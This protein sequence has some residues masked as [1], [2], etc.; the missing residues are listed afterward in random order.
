MG[1][2]QKES[3]G[4]GPPEPSDDGG[5]GDDNKVDRMSQHPSE[6]TEHRTTVPDKFN[7]RSLAG[8]GETYSYEPKMVSEEECLDEILRVYIDLVNYH[9]LMKPATGN[10]NAQK[11][12]LQN[13]PRPEF[14]Y[15]DEDIMRFD[16]WARTLIRW[17][18]VADQCGPESRFSQSR[19]QWVITAVDIQRV[20]TL[21]SFLRGEA[22]EWYNEIVEQIP[23]TFGMDYDTL[24]GHPTFTQVL[25]GLFKNFIHEA[26]LTTVADRFYGVE[27]SNTKGIK[28]SFNELTRLAR[29]MPNPPD[30]YSFK[31]QLF[32]ITPPAMSREMTRTV[33]AE[34]S[35]VNEIME[36]AIKWEKGNGAYIYY[37]KTRMARTPQP[38]SLKWNR[39]NEARD[40][41]DNDDSNNTHH[42]S[43]YQRRPSPKRLQI[44]DRQRYQVPAHATPKQDKPTERRIKTPEPIPG[45]RPR[46]KNMGVCWGCGKPGH[47]QGDPSC[48]ES[49]KS[50]PTKLYRMVDQ[51][52]NARDIRLFRIAAD[53]MIADSNEPSQEK[54]QNDDEI[55]DKYE[56]E[57]PNNEDNHSEPEQWGGSQYESDPIDDEYLNDERIGLMQDYHNSYTDYY[58]QLGM[59]SSHISESE[60]LDREDSQSIQSIHS[61]EEIES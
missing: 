14:Y 53:E 4:G 9:L 1:N 24:T 55:W 46:P 43:R 57:A 13:I 44:V 12:I 15:G 49:E 10:N 8:I 27:Y 60:R 5:S 7:P 26:S 2:L 48:K 16:A 33:T 23:S 47:Y 36:A 56:Q 31:R 45:Q 30:I 29:C 54:H 21:S 50:K 42:R 34:R 20:N 35:S 11:T 25:C 52:G 37:A 19:Q 22:R 39:A 6:N 59:M 3:R 28:G 17:L 58:K 41:T 51:E 61:L 38:S 18:N 40:K 32:I